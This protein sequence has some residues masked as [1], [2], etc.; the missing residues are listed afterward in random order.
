[1]NGGD[2]TPDIMSPL[3]LACTLGKIECVEILLDYGATFTN[4]DAFD[5]TPLM[6]ASYWGYDDIAQLLID[7][8]ADVN[9]TTTNFA[10]GF[11]ATHLQPHVVELLI[12]HG[13]NVHHRNAITSW[14]PSYTLL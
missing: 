5:Q 9:Q 10:L 7:R 4:E 3:S 14:N 8:G 6:H 11:A 12:R 1:V 13:A 2:D